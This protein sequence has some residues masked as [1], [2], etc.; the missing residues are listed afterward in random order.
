MGILSAVF[1]QS[2]F[3]QPGT[4]L[5]PAYLKASKS[6]KVKQPG[7]IVKRAAKRGEK[8]PIPGTSTVF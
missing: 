6:I 1:V 4:G 3:L 8:E 5:L 7:Q 2:I